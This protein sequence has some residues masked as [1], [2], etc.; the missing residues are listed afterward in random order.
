M[1]FLQLNTC[2]WTDQSNRMG[3]MNNGDDQIVQT[4]ASLNMRNA[5][6]ILA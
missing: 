5:A 3:P 2:L 4:E 1:N 6:L